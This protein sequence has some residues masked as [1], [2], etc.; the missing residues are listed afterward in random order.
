MY[1]QIKHIIDCIYNDIKIIYNLDP[2]Y[3]T[4]LIYW[5]QYKTSKQIK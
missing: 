2:S 4:Y 1:M 5:S 3:S